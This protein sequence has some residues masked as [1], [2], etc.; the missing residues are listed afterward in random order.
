MTLH[1]LATKIESTTGLRVIAAH[2]A[3]LNRE[4]IEPFLRDQVRGIKLEHVLDGR[5][6]PMRNLFLLSHDAEAPDL[7]SRASLY[8]FTEDASVDM[9][10]LFKGSD[11]FGYHLN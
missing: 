11:E 7:Q 10:R 8:E 4:R 1:D 2:L 9:D 3:D 5:L 6:K